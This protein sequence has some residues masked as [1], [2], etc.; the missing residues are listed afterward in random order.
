M[1]QWAPWL[2]AQHLHP[3]S[4]EAWVHAVMCEHVPCPRAEALRGHFFF[5]IVVKGSQEVSQEYLE[6]SNQPLNL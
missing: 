5:L 2:C 1:D 4:L 3:E 6:L